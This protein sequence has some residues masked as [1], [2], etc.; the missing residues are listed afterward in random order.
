MA[1]GEKET[2]TEVV[3]AFSLF[4]G[5]DSGGAQSDVITIESL[6]MI[7]KEIGENMTR[8]EL[9]EMLRAAAHDPK[10]QDP[11]KLLVFEDDFLRLMKK[12]A[13]Y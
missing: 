5:A 1:Q 2:R 10:E 13:L 9:A 3:K 12:A 4:A 11:R 7:A 6:E 8:E